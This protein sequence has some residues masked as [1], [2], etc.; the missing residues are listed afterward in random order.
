MVSRQS[1]LVGKNPF[2][3]VSRILVLGSKGRLG[4]ALARKWTANHQVVAWSRSEVDVAD[5][6]TL[7]EKLAQ[8]D[9]DVLVNGTGM[10][11]VDQCE[12]AQEEA[13]IVNVQAPGVMAR[14]AAQKNARFFHVST[15]YVFDGTKDTLYTEEDEAR[16]ISFYGHT[17]VRGEIA[18]LEASPAH[19]VLRISWVFGPDKP[20][21][22]DMMV[23]RALSN[24]H[25]E[26]IA[27]KVS[28]PTYAE[29]VADW[30]E[31]FFDSRLP[32][33]IYHACNAGAC[34][35]RDYGQYAL[36]CVARLGLPLKTQTVHSISMASM[37]N[38]VSL[39]PPFTAMST[40]K[41][42]GTTGLACRPWQEALEEYL[43]KKFKHAP[44]FSP[45]R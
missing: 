1:L 16:P 26:A 15:D 45:D 32:G 8:A 4:A 14:V 28:S 20:S 25:V 2:P 44:L 18:S 41:L 11:N 24:E 17:K 39:R 10:T 37:E 42:S 34:T 3:P 23:D 33:G 36:D 13:E 9:F 27:D 12:I 29:D 21:F 5:L 30:L 31:P 6:S 7:S 40:D 43:T 35:W 19:L 22:I 38:F